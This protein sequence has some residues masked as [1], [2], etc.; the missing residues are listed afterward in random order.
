MSFSIFFSF[1]F[2]FFLLKNIPPVKVKHIFI[3]PPAEDTAYT[4][5]LKNYFHWKKEFIIVSLTGI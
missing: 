5:V 2:F 3:Q 4:G 1:F